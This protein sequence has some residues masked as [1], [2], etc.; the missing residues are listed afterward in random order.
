MVGGLLQLVLFGAQDLYDNFEIQIN[1]YYTH[2]RKYNNFEIQIN[3]DS[4]DLVPV[5][6][7]IYP[8]IINLC[9]LNRDKLFKEYEIVKKEGKKEKR[10]DS[11]GEMNLY[12]YV[13]WKNTNRRTQQHNQR[14][15]KHQINMKRR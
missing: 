2:G 1:T 7:M 4:N 10:T 3:K 15:I 9:N 6:D 8:M 11:G 14:Q 5:L 13:A 12:D